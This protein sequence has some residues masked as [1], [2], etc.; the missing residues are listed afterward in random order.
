MNHRTT[1]GGLDP[2]VVGCPATAS[3]LTVLVGTTTS[4]SE[5]R[6]FHPRRRGGR[7]AEGRTPLATRVPSGMDRK[8]HIFAYREPSRREATDVCF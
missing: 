2:L 7:R 4:G 6:G 1:L 8:A 5:R 3:V